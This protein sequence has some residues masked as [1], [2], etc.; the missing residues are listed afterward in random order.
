MIVIKIPATLFLLKLFWLDPEPTLYIWPRAV[1][2]HKPARSVRSRSQCV[3]A[4]MLAHAHRVGARS[5]FSSLCIVHTPVYVPLL[6]HAC[7]CAPSC[8]PPCV[9]LQRAPIH[10]CA[11]RQVTYCWLCRPYL[12]QLMSPLGL[13][14]TGLL[15]EPVTNL[16]GMFG[17]M[18]VIF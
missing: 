1:L 4:P 12:P 13:P 16:L 14:F 2:S 7:S 10:S 15:S 5:T 18:F 3:E 8:A 11:Q 6:M 17:G 9:S